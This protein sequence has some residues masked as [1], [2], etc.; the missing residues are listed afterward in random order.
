ME[1]RGARKG[2]AR[3]KGFVDTQSKKKGTSKNY[4]YRTRTYSC[5]TQNEESNQLNEPVRRKHDRQTQRESNPHDL[6]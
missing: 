4:G 5:L 3:E 6:F 1:E 2:R